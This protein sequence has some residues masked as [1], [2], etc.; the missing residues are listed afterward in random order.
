MAQEIHSTLPVEVQAILAGSKLADIDIHALT[1]GAARI[2]GL[3]EHA[4][5]QAAA[6]GAVVIEG[7]LVTVMPLPLVAGRGSMLVVSVNTGRSLQD[8]GL[9]VAAEL[10]A[11]APGLL[12][13]FEVAIGCQPDGMI[14]LHRAVKADEL[15]PT[16]LAHCML[17]TRRLTPL[18]GLEPGVETEQQ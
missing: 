8:L 18:L 7:A 2:L 17:A 1:Q 4:A 10:F 3:D 16:E 12:A 11:H 9:Q 13:V 14:V 5:M 15:E 6:D